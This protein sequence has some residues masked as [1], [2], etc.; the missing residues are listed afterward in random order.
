MKADHHRV[1]LG[2]HVG[3]DTLPPPRTRS[4]VQACAIPPSSLLGGERPTSAYF[5]DAYRA[6][7]RRPQASVVDIFFAI[8]GHHPWW[9]KAALIVRNVLASWCGL[10]APRAAEIVHLEVKASYRV[11]ETIG[12]WQLYAL[13]DIEL[14]AGRDN[15]HLDFRFSVL[16]ETNGEVPSVVVSTQCTVHNRFGKVYLFFVVPFHKWGVQRLMSRAIIAQRL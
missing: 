4:G 12:V 13:T 7:L 3:R 6:P 8:L 5:W 11:G 15:K 10:D 14:I 2:V 1:V 16:K 9:M